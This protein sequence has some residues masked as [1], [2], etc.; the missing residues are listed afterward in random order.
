MPRPSS[1]G[2]RVIPALSLPTPASLKTA[3]KAVDLQ[4]HL[5]V[6]ADQ[7]AVRGGDD[8]LALVLGGDQRGRVDQH[9]APAPSGLVEHAPGFAGWHRGR[10]RWGER[11]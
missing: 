2:S 3:A 1:A 5:G 4:R 7:R 10:D 9:D 6:A 8:D 11:R